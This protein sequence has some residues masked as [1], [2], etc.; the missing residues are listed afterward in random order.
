MEFLKYN[1]TKAQPYTISGYLKLVPNVNGIKVTNTGADLVFVNDEPLYPGLP[2]TAI[3]DS[4]TIG[5]NLGEIFLGTVDIRFSGTGT[6]PQVLAT[7]K[8]YILPGQ[9]Y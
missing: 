6:N 8:F 9:I 3:G 2:G 4:I 7:I 1:I 5:G